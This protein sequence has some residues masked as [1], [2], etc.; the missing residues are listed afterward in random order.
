MDYLYRQ[1]DYQVQRY[2]EDQ[3]PPRWEPLPMVTYPERTELCGETDHLSLFALAIKLPKS[4][5]PFVDVT[6]TPKPKTL[7]DLLSD[8]FGHGSDGSTGQP[9][10]VYEP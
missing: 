7:I 5:T 8:I 9:D 4:G 2:E 6:P 10:G 1:D 3:D